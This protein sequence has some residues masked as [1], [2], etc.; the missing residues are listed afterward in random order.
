[1][2]QIGANQYN[3]GSDVGDHPETK[4]KYSRFI[5]GLKM[6]IVICQVVLDVLDWFPL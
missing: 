4:I 2:R 5:G 6:A 3:F 1:L